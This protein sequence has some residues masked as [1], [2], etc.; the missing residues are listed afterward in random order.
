MQYSSVTLVIIQLV[1]GILVLCLS[2][3][4]TA[5]IQLTASQQCP[6]LA[7]R[8][9][10]HPNTKHGVLAGKGKAQISVIL[11]TK[12]PISDLNFKMTLPSGMSVRRTATRPSIKP[13]MPPEVVGNIDG[14][15]A[16][17][18]LDIDFSRRS[19]RRF[20]VKVNIDLCAPEHLAVDAFA[21]LNNATSTWCVTPSASP[22]LLRA[23]YPKQKPA[24]C[25]PT[26]APSVNPTQ[27]FVVFAPGQRFSQGGQLAPF[28]NRRLSLHP[29]MNLAMDQ[30]ILS[31][32]DTYHRQLQPIETKD[33]CYEYCSLVG[34]KI[35]PFFFSWNNA[36]SQCYCCAT[37]CTPF[38]YDPAFDVQKVLVSA[39]SAPTFTPAPTPSDQNRR[40]YNITAVRTILD[41]AEAS[42][43]C[44][45][46]A[47]EAWNCR[48]F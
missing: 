31:F 20:R 26:L 27:S 11:R 14:T 7:I 9:K 16:L 3:L 37:V 2:Q 29:E 42:Y 40:L 28:D 43:S 32:G 4:S 13:H 12:D 23:R 34:G 45:T 35:A 48:Y 38:I 21:Y 47:C 25:A 18:W 5:S 15:T 46:S 41:Y 6:R 33:D 17:Y 19:K 39:T 22:A 44:K 24:T 36:T 30:D 10:A 1:L 8:A